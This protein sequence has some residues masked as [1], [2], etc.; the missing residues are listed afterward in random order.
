M[1]SNIKVRAFT[2][3]ECLVALLV[4]SGSV[5]VYQAMTGVVT[6]NVAYISH[7]EEEDWLLFC[8]QMRYE[9][10]ATKLDKVADNK[11]YVSKEGQSL[12][13]GQAPAGDFRKSNSD[14]RGYQPMIYRIKSSSITKSGS[15]I[16]IQIS[17]QSGLERTFTYA[18]EEES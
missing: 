13:F 12:A 18:F 2:L 9:L 11:L 17:F 3:M 10:S 7:S 14:G 1:F 6:Q 16:H 15:L 4:M 5:L 8:Q